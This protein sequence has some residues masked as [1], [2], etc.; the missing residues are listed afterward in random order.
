M[1]TYDDFIEKH[2]EYLEDKPTVRFLFENV[3]KNLNLVYKHDYNL[4]EHCEELSGMTGWVIIFEQV[5]ITDIDGG[6]YFC[7]SF[8]YLKDGSIVVK[9]ISLKG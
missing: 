5:L 2:K 7:V 1:D 9:S 8:D 4:Q 3:V 6:L